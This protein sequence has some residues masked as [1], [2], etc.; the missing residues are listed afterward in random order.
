MAIVGCSRKVA[1]K[2]SVIRVNTQQVV[3]ASNGV[4]NMTILLD[5]RQQQ[6]TAHDNLSDALCDYHHARTKYLIATGRKE[7]TY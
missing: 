7:Q 6:Q 2:E 1:P 4:T 5:A 3:T